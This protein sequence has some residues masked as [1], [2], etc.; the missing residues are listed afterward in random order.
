MVTRR[1]DM[2]ITPR[3]KRR[4]E[5]STRERAREERHIERARNR[6]SRI[7]R[8]IRRAR[9]LRKRLAARQFGRSQRGAAASRAANAA[10]RRRAIGATAAKAIGIAAVA[11]ELLIE[12]GRVARALGGKSGRLINAEDANT[13]YGDLDEQATA[14]AET[15]GFVES[16]SS[17]L[18]IIARQGKV[19]SQIT[20]IAQDLKRLA[21]MRAR[22]SDLIEREP[23]FD[24]PDR[25][26]DKLIKKAAELDLK[27]L[28]DRAALLLK[29]NTGIGALKSTR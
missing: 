6:K 25:I 12:G 17:L 7:F 23:A 29:Q 2:T 5:T 15:R 8:R 19:N 13:I 11:V 16:K 18:R 14:S 21:L 1:E 28:A 9:R 10:A 26:M 22:G 3:L 20:S 27:G 24:S 4:E